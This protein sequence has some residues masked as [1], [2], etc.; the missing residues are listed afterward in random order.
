MMEEHDFAIQMQEE[1]I[2]EIESAQ[3]EILVVVNVYESW[4]MR[5]NSHL[6]L[7]EWFESYWTRHYQM[8]G[9]ADITSRGTKYYWLPDVKWPPESDSYIAVFKRKT[10]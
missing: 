5:P 4:L 7:L 6:L 2:R 9:T 10:R 1:M 8:I 3:P